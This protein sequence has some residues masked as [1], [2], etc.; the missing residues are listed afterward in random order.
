MIISSSYTVRYGVLKVCKWSILVWLLLLYTGISF[1]Y[2][3]GWESEQPSFFYANDPFFSVTGYNY[4]NMTDL[5]IYDIHTR[6][7][8]VHLAWRIDCDYL[9]CICCYYSML[10]ITSVCAYVYARKQYITKHMNRRGMSMNEYVLFDNILH[11]VSWCPSIASGRFTV[12]EPMYVI[13]VYYAKYA[14]KQI[15]LWEPFNRCL[16]AR[17]VDSVKYL[18]F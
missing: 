9:L 14:R 4:S 5:I 10:I 7:H 17:I 11:N 18:C 12:N 8:F 13:S 15:N 6:T 3:S 2:S 1:I 16:H